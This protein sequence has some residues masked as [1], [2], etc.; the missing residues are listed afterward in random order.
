MCIVSY[1]QRLVLNYPQYFILQQMRRLKRKPS[2][3]RST[4]NSSL[5][6]GSHL[7]AVEIEKLNFSIVEILNLHN[8]DRRWG[9]C[10]NFEEKFV[11]L[12]WVLNDC[13]SSLKVFSNLALKCQ[14]FSYQ[15]TTG[16]NC[17]DWSLTTSPNSH[18]SLNKFL[19][20]IS[21][22]FPLVVIKHKM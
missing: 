22:F 13:K 4:W 20:T 2:L 1:P 18:Q 3:P 17:Y 8:R 15:W 6:A 5:R 11:S 12:S 19:W 9:H 21:C 10:G 14:D 7:L 16:A